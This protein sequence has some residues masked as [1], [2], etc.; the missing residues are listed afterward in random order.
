MDAFEMDALEMDALEMD[1]PF[2]DPV[3]NALDLTA[4]EDS[5]SDHDVEYVEGD[6]ITG[7]GINGD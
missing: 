5:T 7:S 1:A 6:I 3:A 4:N 2:A